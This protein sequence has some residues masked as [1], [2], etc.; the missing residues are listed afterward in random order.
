MAIQSTGIGSGLD[1]NNL[2]S[3]LMQVESQPLVA[4]AK[5]E[6]SF[7][8]KLSAYGS[9]KGAVSAFQNSLTA[10]NTPSTFQTL[11][12]S[13]SDSTVLSASVFEKSMAYL[14]RLRNSERR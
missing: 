11:A 12:G 9:L 13:S 8:A 3:K 6:A 1:V 14:R 5:K 4:L 10:L 7:Q 2:I